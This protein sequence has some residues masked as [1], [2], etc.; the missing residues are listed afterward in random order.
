MRAFQHILHRVAFVA[1]LVLFATA[2]HADPI[3]NATGLANPGQTITFDEF[4]YAPGTAITDQYES[5]GVIFSPMAFYDSQGPAGPFTG[6]SGNYLG[7]SDGTTENNPISILFTSPEIAAAV[8]IATNTPVGL[9]TVTALMDGTAVQ[10]FKLGTDVNDPGFVGFEF[11]GFQGVTFNEITI[12]AGDQNGAML[13]DNIQTISTVPEPS[14]VALFAIG[15]LG[16]LAIPR[17]RK[18]VSGLL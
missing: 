4:M 15:A 17:Q 18:R 1:C 13:L 9:T 6:I 12:D 5:L 2:A 3:A 11:L 14:T 10:Q 16:L 8:G 7:N